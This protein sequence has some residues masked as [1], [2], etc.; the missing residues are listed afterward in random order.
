MFEDNWVCAHLSRDSVLH[1]KIEAR[2]REPESVPPPRPVQGRR[3]GPGTD[4]V[5]DALTKAL[6][7]PADVV[8]WAVMMHFPSQAQCE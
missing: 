8:H 6:P 5:A 2:G 3:D 7:L 1:H 4:Q